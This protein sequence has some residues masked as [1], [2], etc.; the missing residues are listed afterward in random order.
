M[1]FYNELEVNESAVQV[2]GDEILK[3]I[4]KEIAGKVRPTRRLTGR[5]GRAQGP[6]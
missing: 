3:D 2:L 6:G 1:A 4:A 5:Y